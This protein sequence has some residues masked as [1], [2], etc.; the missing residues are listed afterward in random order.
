LP[1]TGADIEMAL[2]GIFAGRAG[3]VSLGLVMGMVPI[4]K[5][6]HRQK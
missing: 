2:R 1:E 3:W 5:N 6:T 4:R